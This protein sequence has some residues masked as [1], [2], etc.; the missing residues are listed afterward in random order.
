MRKCFIFDFD[1]TLAGFSVYNTMTYV[2]PI[3]VFPQ[4]GGTLRDVPAVLDFLSEKGDTLKMV[5]MNI[6][7]KEE[8]KWRKLERVG[9]LKWFHKRNV[10]MVRR[11]TPDLFRK[12]CRGKN[13]RMCY[14]VGNS[15]QHDIIPSLEAGI[16]AIYIPKPRLKKFLPN[17]VSDHENLIVLGSIREIR[18]RYDRL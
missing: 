1:D 2:S 16:N 6:V 4:L 18:E 14:M 17:P 9:M 7:L 10:W 8:Q 5:T 3:R 11:K 15:L 12:I 13:P